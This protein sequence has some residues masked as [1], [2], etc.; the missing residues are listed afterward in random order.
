MAEATLEAIDKQIVSWVEQLD[1]LYE[2]RRKIIERIVEVEGRLT[3]MKIARRAL[4]AEWGD[5]SEEV[6]I[7]L[8]YTAEGVTEAIHEVL[9]DAGSPQT[10][11]QIVSR[12]RR[13]RFNFGEK[14]RRRVVNMALVNDGAIQ[15]NGEGEYT[16]IWESF[17]KK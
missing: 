1:I 2:E 9:N 12:L 15:S 14:N 16:Y 11:D 17:G 5:T 6:P 4:A 10:V 7:P 3:A 13:K 8:E